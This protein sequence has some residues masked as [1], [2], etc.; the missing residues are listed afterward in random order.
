MTSILIFLLVLSLLIAVHELGH[1][2]AAKAC[3]VYVD[4]FSIGMPPRVFGF[5]YGET[6]YCIGALP[7]GGYVKMA[8][9]E[10]APLSEEE[11]DRDYGH[12]T[13][14]RWFNN[15]PVWQRIII[16]LAGP[17]MNL[18]LAVGIYAGL[19]AWGTMVPEY[20]INAKI[21]RIEPDSPAASAPLYV[22]RPG[23]AFSEY[24]GEP[25]ATGWLPGDTIISLDGKHMSN[26]ADVAVEALLGGEGTLHHL[27]I[28]RANEDGGGVTR[29]VS[30]VAPRKLSE[31]DDYP[32]FGVSH[33]ESARVTMVMEGMPAASSGLQPDDIIERLDGV[34]IDR[35]SFIKRVEE[36]PDGTPL[37]LGVRRGEERMEVLITPQTIGRL[38]GLAY[39]G[40]SK[41]KG[42]AGIPVI[43]VTEEFKEKSKLQRKDIILA[44]NGEPATPERLSELER[45]NPGGVLNVKVE[46]PA[47]LFGL[48][49]Q[50]QEIELQLPVEPVRAV[51]IGLAPLEVFYQPPAS[52]VIPEAFQRSFRAVQQTVD[53]VVGL[54]NQNVGMKDIG[55]PVMIFSITAQAA[56][57]GWAILAKTTAFISI[58]LCVI[59]LL[60]LPIL[61]GGQIVLNTME[62]I[63]RRPMSPLFV[64][65]YQMVGFVL[66]VA[67]MLFVTW[68]D[69]GRMITGLRP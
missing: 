13:P 28:E 66:I 52:Q 57:A 20:E 33:F 63:R 38:R 31:S 18:V 21:G 61:D 37:R 65:R 68:N 40:K 35:V 11:R 27:V 23:A 1:F 2:L 55:G 15:K 62:A 47:I 69:V 8:G 5:K 51:G 45:A 10:D 30:P 59:N 34:L 22:Q 41:G 60:P 32:R 3:G 56:E 39:A 46:R 50:R 58:N 67:L 44:V 43:D 24:T 64:E 54:I 16:L 6:D 26:I 14:D 19:L 12:V 48:M 29:Y 53:T 25:A 7:F 4:R 42:A 49:Q 36:T 9:Q 17:F